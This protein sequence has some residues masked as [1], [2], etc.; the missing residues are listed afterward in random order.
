MKKNAAVVAANTQVAADIAEMKM[1]KAALKAD[2]MVGKK[3]ALKCN[4]DSD[5]KT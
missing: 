1:N 3:Y 4:L 5:K 2:K